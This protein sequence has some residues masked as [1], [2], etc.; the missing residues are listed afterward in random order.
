[1]V[2][3]DLSTVTLSDVRIFSTRLGLSAFQKKSEYG[4]AKI[5]IN[6]LILKENELDYLIENRFQS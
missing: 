6:N 4:V 3:K 5:A 1:M 2:S